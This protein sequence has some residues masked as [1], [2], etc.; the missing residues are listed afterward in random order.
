MYCLEAPSR[1]N[2]LFQLLGM[3][4]QTASSCQRLH[5]LCQLQRTVPPKSMPLGGPFLATDN[6]E[7]ITVTSAHWGAT[8]MDS[9]APELPKSWPR[10]YCICIITQLFL[11]LSFA[12]YLS[13]FPNSWEVLTSN[14]FSTFQTPSQPLL[15]EHPTWTSY[16]RK[17]SAQEFSYN[18]PPGHPGDSLW[19][20]AMLGSLFLGPTAFFLWF[21]LLFWCST[22]SSS[23]LRKIYGRSSFLNHACPNMGLFASHLIN[24]SVG[25]NLLGRK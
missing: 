6:G 23:F 25:Y 24:S 7:V 9:N 5:L 2:L 22:F 11:L 16:S 3:S 8:P 20:I 21:I 14:K 10:L 18:T 17:A 1:R 15:L 12:S 4:Q 13:L 19:C